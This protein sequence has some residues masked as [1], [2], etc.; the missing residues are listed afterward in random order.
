MN[1]EQDLMQKLLDVGISTRRGVMTIHREKAYEKEIDLLP[2]SENLADKSII[3]P[4]YVGMSDSQI[5]YV[6][7][8]LKLIIQKIV[9]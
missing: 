4:L 9:I 7:D 3:L 1:S 8:S 6:I 2:I 5:D